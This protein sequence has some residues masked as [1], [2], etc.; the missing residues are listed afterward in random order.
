MKL[1]KPIS[2]SLVALTVKPS[3]GPIIIVKPPST[4]KATTIHKMDTETA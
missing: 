2:I 3:N 1:A 4:A